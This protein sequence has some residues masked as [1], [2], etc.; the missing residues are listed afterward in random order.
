[1]L[2]RDQLLTLTTDCHTTNVNLHSI[3][4]MAIQI[5]TVKV[6]MTD[7]FLVLAKLKEMRANIIFITN[8]SL[9][10]KHTISHRAHV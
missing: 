10:G 3:V 8:A 2:K 6:V 5:L 1:M 4:T 7:L 9:C